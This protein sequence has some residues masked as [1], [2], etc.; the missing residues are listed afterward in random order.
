MK[1]VFDL[2]VVV[3]LILWKRVRHNHDWMGNCKPGCSCGEVV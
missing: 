3:V 2:G 1:N